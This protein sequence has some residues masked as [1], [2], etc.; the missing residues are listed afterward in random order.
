M[1]LN[2]LLLAL[3]MASAALPALAQSTA[4]PPPPAEP[5]VIPPVDRR[6]V[7]LPRYPSNDLEIGAYTGTYAT[8]NFGTSWVY[9]ARVGYHLTEDFFVQAVYGQTKV[10]D[11]SFRQILPGGVFGSPTQKLAYYN[12]SVGYNILPGEVFLFSSRARPSQLFLVGGVG[13]TKFVD[14]RKPTYNFGFG[15]RVFLTDY[16]SLQLDLRDHIF[17]LDLLGKN[18]TTQNLELTAGLSFYF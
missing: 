9:G 2:K 1:N 5:V 3:C 13:S 10:S 8:E 12:L 7:R 17:S 4:P 6:D 15:F 11:E 18:Q 14:Q 16:A